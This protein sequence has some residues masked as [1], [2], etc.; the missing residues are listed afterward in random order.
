MLA[1]SRCLNANRP[2]KRLHSTSPH[3]IATDLH[4]RVRI[5]LRDTAQ[6]VAVITSYM[7]SSSNSSTDSP[8]H[9]FHGATLSSFASISMSPHPLVAFSLRVPSR[10]ATTLSLLSSGDLTQF[11]HTNPE[12]I[13]PETHFVANILSASQPRTAL[14]FSRPDLHPRPFDDVQWS[15]T[16]EGLPIVH[17]SLGA[18]SCRIVAG[19]WPLHDLDAL[20]GRDEKQGEAERATELEVGA[21][22]VSSE[23]FIARVMRVEDVPLTEAKANE[24]IRDDA[25]RTLPL[26]YHRRR[27]ASTQDLETQPS[28]GF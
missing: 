2:H 15:S 1:R 4:S 23:L 17:D 20:G 19:P 26:L 21:G 27:Y 8:T 10:M 14:L 6:P 28:S 22:E 7:P 25:L 9:P 24:A 5:L 18:M 11:Q 12:R 3:N 16:A 13:L